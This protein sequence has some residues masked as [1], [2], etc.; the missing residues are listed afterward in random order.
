ML[1]ISLCSGNFGAYANSVHT[2]LFPAPAT[3]DARYLSAYA[4]HAVGARARAQLSVWC[5][6]NKLLC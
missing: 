5:Y 1:F 3:H 6:G 2:V 4:V